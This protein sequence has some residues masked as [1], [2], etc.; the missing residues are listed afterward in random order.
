MERAAVSPILYYES[1]FEIDNAGFKSFFKLWHFA[2]DVCDQANSM[3][4]VSGEERKKKKK[5]QKKHQ[6]AHRREMGI[7]KS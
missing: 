5:M 2:Y 3:S 4:V 6:E 7:F 1:R